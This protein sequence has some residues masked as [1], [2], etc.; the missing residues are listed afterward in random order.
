MR[1]TKEDAL[2]TRE[3]ILDAAEARFYDFGVAST[4][5]SHIAAA[6]G[7]TRG[8]IYWHFPNKLELF[9]AMHER[10]KLPQEA[11]FSDGS[12]GAR[13]SLE[14]LY[15][16]SIEAFRHLERDER[17]RRVLTILLLRCEYVGEMQDAMMRRTDADNAM[18][19]T[20]TAI[21]AAVQ[22]RGELKPEWKPEIAATAYVCA[23][24]GVI[25]EWLRSERGF[26]LVTVGGNVVRSVIVG[27]AC[28][29]APVACLEENSFA[30][31]AARGGEDQ[32]VARS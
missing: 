2:L 18:H 10:A 31:E 6:A 24:G 5:L 15:T 13:R 26:D 30:A 19:R 23:V 17:A 27:F 4:T 7:L 22:Y 3:A 9:R 12:P 20:I 1:R 8:A 14:E 28:P 21:F 11:F 29:G 32:A 25:L 16:N